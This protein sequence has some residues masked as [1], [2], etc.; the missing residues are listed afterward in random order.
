ME[1]VVDSFE[2]AEAAQSAG[3]N[4]VELCSNLIEGGCTPSL[5]LA[6]YIKNKLNIPVFVMIRPRGG[7]FLYSD[8]EFEVMKLDI[9]EFKKSNVDGFVF[10]ILK[11]DGNIDKDR[12]QELVDLCKPQSVTFHRAFDVCVDGHQALE[13]IISLGFDRILTS[14]RENSCLE[15]LP[16]LASLV[17]KAG[18]RIIIM[19]GGGIT[20]KNF[21]RIKDGCNAKE[22]HWSARSTKDSGMY[23]RRSDIY[24]GSPLYPSEYSIKVCSKDRIDKLRAIL[25]CT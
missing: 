12:N 4:R 2:S 25:S 24:M 21:L 17:E 14:G 6:Q 16:M 22:Y 7:D 9:K 5:G 13:D 18:D 20:E 11:S 3:A 19:P 23:H 1:I 8:D 10:G 15:G